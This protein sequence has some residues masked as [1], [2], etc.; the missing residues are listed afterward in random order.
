L[1][2]RYEG[3]NIDLID[4]ISKILGFNYSVQIVADGSYGSYNAKTDTWN[5]MIGE[6]LSQ[7]ADLA[8]ADLTIT[9]EREQVIKTQL[10]SEIGTEIKT[11]KKEIEMSFDIKQIIY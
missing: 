10:L 9:Y 6:L 11:R 5:G 1:P 3:Y 4:E 8:V 2:N 7:K